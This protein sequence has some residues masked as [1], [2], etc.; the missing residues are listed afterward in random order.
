MD[1]RVVVTGMGMVT[2]LGR[3]LEQTW[4]TLQEGRSGVD[5][6]S[7]FDASSFPTQIAAEVKNFRLDDYRDDADRWREHCRN[8]QFALAAATM[9]ID[10]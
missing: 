6:I 4:A 3:D 7:L 5:R 2:P 8:T 10:H 1:R 9:A